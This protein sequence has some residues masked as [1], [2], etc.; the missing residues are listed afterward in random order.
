MDRSYRVV[1]EGTDTVVLAAA[2]VGD[3]VGT[4]GGIEEGKDTLDHCCTSVD[5]G[6]D[7]MMHKVRGHREAGV[8]TLLVLVLGEGRSSAMHSVVVDTAQLRALH[9]PHRIVG[10]QI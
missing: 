6:A 4:G 2:V 1:V 3:A 10:D 9:H 5:R 8:G 7:C